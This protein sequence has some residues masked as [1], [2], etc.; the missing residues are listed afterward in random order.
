MSFGASDGIN[1]LS[2]TWMI[3]LLVITS[4]IVTLA[5]LTMTPPSTVKASGWPLTASADMH[6]LT[7][8]AGTSP[9]TT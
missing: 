4:G 8:A 2:M 6:S 7:F 3:P 1:T 9:A 5:S